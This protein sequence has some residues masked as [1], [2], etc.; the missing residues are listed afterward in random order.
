MEINFRAYSK[1]SILEGYLFQELNIV[2]LGTA[3]EKLMQFLGLV[4]KIFLLSVLF[5][6]VRPNKLRYDV[7]YSRCIVGSMFSMD[8]IC[9]F[10]HYSKIYFFNS[11]KGYVL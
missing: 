2:E 6:K 9:N 4:P 11:I 7:V 8:V 5:I 3:K 10:L 1:K